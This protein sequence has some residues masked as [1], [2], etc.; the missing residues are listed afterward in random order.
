MLVSKVF[1]TCWLKHFCRT[2]YN[3]LRTL[4]AAY[5]DTDG[6]TGFDFIRTRFQGHKNLE[7]KRVKSY[8]SVDLALCSLLTTEKKSFFVFLT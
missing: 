4:K 5:C 3:P 7:L 6:L 2:L 8:F 1:Q